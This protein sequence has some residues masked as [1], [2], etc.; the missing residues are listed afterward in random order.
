VSNWPI[1]M[2]ARSEAWIV[3]AHSRHAC[4][5]CVHLWCVCVVLCVGREVLRRAAPPSK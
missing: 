1:T 4:L 2:A 3:F 5:C